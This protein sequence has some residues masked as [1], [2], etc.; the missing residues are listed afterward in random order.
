MDHGHVL[1]DGHS[2]EVCNQFYDQSNAKINASLSGAKARNIRE[3]DDV[4][5]EQV[6]ILDD[7]NQVTSRIQCLSP[8]AFRMRF[9]VQ[10]PLKEIVFLFGTHTTDFVYLGA[11]NS[12]GN[13]QDF[14]PGTYTVTARIETM[15]L[16]PGTYS[17]RVWIGTPHGKE[18]FYAENLATFQIYSDEYLIS[19]QQGM[20]LIFMED[21]WDFERI[22]SA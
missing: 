3:S 4:R 21:K 10:Q 17:C 22:V 20:G 12:G 11:N 14:E 5:V 19:Q 8:M 9:T 2:T 16:L 6:D 13:A 15:R 18:Y 7:D 1:K